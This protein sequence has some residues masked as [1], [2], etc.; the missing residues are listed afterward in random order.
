MKWH[1]R[2]AVNLASS[3]TCRPASKHHHAA[4]GCVSL[5]L[6]KQPCKLCTLGLRR[7]CTHSNNWQPQRVW[8]FS[9]SCTAV[10]SPST[11]RKQQQMAAVAC[12]SNA[13]HKLCACTCPASSHAHAVHVDTLGARRPQTIPQ[14]AI[15]TCNIVAA[16]RCL[17]PC[18]CDILVLGGVP[19][20]AGLSC[21]GASYGMLC[22]WPQL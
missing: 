7:G 17:H 1:N 8:R 5:V 15:K 21:C 12:F 19:V 11:V 18:V 4:V 20:P 14:Q 22:H 16:K 9:F 13:S 10:T 3:Q 2:S 6:S